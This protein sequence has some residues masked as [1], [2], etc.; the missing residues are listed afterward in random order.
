MKD[1]NRRS[2]L[3][4][5]LAAATATPLLTL[6]S[7]AVAAKVYGLYDRDEHVLRKTTLE[8]MSH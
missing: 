8:E 5:G 3:A 2:A 1:M 4:F 6:A 7:P